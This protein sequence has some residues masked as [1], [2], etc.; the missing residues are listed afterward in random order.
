MYGRKIINFDLD[1]PQQKLTYSILD[2]ARYNQTKLIIKLLDDFFKKYNITPA[3]SYDKVKAIV[4]LY[5]LDDDMSGVTANS[6]PVSEAVSVTQ[7]TQSQDLNNILLTLLLSQTQN[8]V[9]T[10]PTM[11][12]PT[13]N[14]PG[15]IQKEEPVSSEL[16]EKPK[17][18]NK[19]SQSQKKIVT[20]S[21]I[22]DDEDD[23]YEDDDNPEYV[24][25][26]AR[27]FRNLIE[28]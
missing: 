22:E 18:N 23:D 26:A 10:I 1:D 24:S 4:K 13:V 14:A 25:V 17:N 2:K 8:N 6:S 28:E 20:D 27:S 21:D 11:A 9:A 7:N 15:G 5:L 19:V 12:I 3:T 16:K